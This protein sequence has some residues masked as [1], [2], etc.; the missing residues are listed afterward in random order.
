[1]KRENAVL[2]RK[3]KQYSALATPMLATAALANAQVVY[4]DINPDVILS[5]P[6]DS[7]LLDLNNDGMFDYTFR[8][9]AYTL[10]W[11]RACVGPANVSGVYT[12]ADQ[13]AVIGYYNLGSGGKPYA[14]ASALSL[15]QLIDDN[16]PMFVIQD[17]L[18]TS[19]GN[20]K[21]YLPVM[22]SIFLTVQYGQWKD[23]A[24]HFAGL[25][26]TPDSG[27]TFYFGWARCIVTTDAKTMTI[28]DYAYQST[29]G[30]PIAAG[31]G[32]NIGIGTQGEE[33]GV[34]IFSFNNCLNLSIKATKV[35]D[36]SIH[37]INVLG[38]EILNQKIN[39]AQSTFSL[40][41][42]P[43]GTYI[44]QVRFEDKEVTKK[45]VVN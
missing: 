1:V 5:A 42:L 44:V 43:T 19:S 2:L 6:G 7:L 15:G 12:T 17:L 4:H 21:F 10:F 37:L 16:Q 39:S 3:L 30:T 41:R 36:A 31:E 23:G 18:F 26:F 9:V 34:Q 27:A 29:A 35:S 32:T 14:Y 45:I 20:N 28:K 13:N 33:D 25:K 40:N 22:N 11:N 38:Q 24:E 8:T